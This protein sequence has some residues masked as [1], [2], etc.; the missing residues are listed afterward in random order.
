[1]LAA[2]I[3]KNNSG[4]ATIADV[5]ATEQAEEQEIQQ[6]QR[7]AGQEDVHDSLRTLIEL[8]PV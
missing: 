3:A 2:K 7:A 5:A 1:L 6:Q 8:T 4:S